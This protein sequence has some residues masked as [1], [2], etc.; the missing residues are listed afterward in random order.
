M[1]LAEKTVTESYK[2]GFIDKDIMSGTLTWKRD[3]VTL[4]GAWRA[5]R[6]VETF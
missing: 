1:I 6:M 5:F 3:G 2:G 4:M